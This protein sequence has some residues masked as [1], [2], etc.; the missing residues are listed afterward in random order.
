MS[1]S[2]FNIFF[3]PFRPEANVFFHVLSD[4]P[5]FLYILCSSYPVLLE[6]MIKND[7]LL[8]IGFNFMNNMLCGNRAHLTAKI[9]NYGSKLLRDVVASPLLKP[10]RDALQKK[11]CRPGR[12]Y[13]LEAGNTV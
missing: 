5:I 3:S 12:N 11:C 4:N 9:I 8:K 7:L 10:F 1:I 6:L 13:R 2:L